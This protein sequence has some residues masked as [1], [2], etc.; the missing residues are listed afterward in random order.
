MKCVNV[1]E[2]IYPLLNGEKSY[3]PYC[4]VCFVLC[5]LWCVLWCVLCCVLCV[6]SMH[7]F[8]VWWVL[9][10]LIRCSIYHACICFLLVSFVIQFK[11]ICKRDLTCLIIYIYIFCSTFKC[12]LV[13]QYDLCMKVFT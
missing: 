8:F 6:C 1:C 3:F 9:N 7:V 12:S 10:T 11:E 2:K 4:V 5:V 13:Q